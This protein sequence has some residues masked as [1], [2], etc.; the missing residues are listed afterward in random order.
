ME[1]KLINLASHLLLVWEATRGKG[2]MDN[3]GQDNPKVQQTPNIDALQG[4]SPTEM[5]TSIKKEPEVQEMYN[6][7]RMRFRKPYTYSE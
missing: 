7:P 2:E 3:G 6:S 1:Y 5:N 4:F